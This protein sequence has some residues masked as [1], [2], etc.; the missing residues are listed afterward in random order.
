MNE[1]LV[2]A[3]DLKIIDRA[4]G[5]VT[6]LPSATSSAPLLTKVMRGGKRVARPES[7]FETRERARK[8]VTSLFDRYRRLTA[9]RHFPVGMTQALT[10][11]KADLVAA[12][13]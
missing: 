5:F 9:P 4:T 7:V 12:S 11:L 10:T 1:R 3:R 13:A 2:G 8:A 6:R